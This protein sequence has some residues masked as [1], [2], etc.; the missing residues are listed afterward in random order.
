MSFAGVRNE[1]LSLRFDL[2]HGIALQSILD[3]AI[4][5]EYLRKA[6]SALFEYAVNNGTPLEST[7]LSVIS[8]EPPGDGSSEDGPSLSVVASDGQ[9]TFSLQV[10]LPVG[11]P[12]AILHLSITTNSELPLFVRVVMPKLRGL[13][14]EDNASQM[15]GA[16]PQEVGSVIPMTS[17][18]ILGMPFGSSKLAPSVGLPTSYNNMELAASTIRYRAA[19]SSFATSMETS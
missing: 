8:V 3:A 11:E 15:M 1:S 4:S 2:T 12:A 6:P 16:I 19:A 13:I 14:T 18:V 17:D 5:R 7:Q 10:S 9:L